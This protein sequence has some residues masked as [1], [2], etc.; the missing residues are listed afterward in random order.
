MISG[1][2]VALVTP[3]LANGELDW[4]GLQRLV[5]FH[6]EQRTDA[7]LVCGT[8]GESATLTVTEQGEIIEQVLAGVGGRIPVIVGCSS[9]ATRDAVHLA[10]QARSLGADACLV[11]AP[12]YN[13]PTQEGLYQHFL[14]ISRAVP[15]PMILYN[16]PGRTAV[17][18][19]PE[20]VER[21][22]DLDTVIAIKE[23][24]GS[25]ERALVLLERVG[26][27]MAVLSGDDATAAELVLKGGS[28]VIS[29]TANVAPAQMHKLCTLAREG[30]EQQARALNEH[31]LP[32]HEVLFA[33]TNPI[34]V[35]YA[36]HR[37]QLI[38]NGIRL[39]LTPLSTELHA[40]VD[41]ALATTEGPLASAQV[42]QATFKDA[43]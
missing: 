28:G 9:S 40:R 18:I 39:P 11:A 10:A 41:E 13:K 24:S 7:I 23:A 33:E 26:D 42:Q 17:D 21:L 1:S 27:R 19:L 43:R 15:L 31:L 32:L 16:V 20:T 25:L 5:Q 14:S 36:L 35:K 6:L 29:V 22:A 30:K 12:A 3:M 38:D 4:D 37:M 34:P 8:T 2:V